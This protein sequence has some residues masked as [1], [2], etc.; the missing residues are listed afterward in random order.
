MGEMGKGTRKRRQEYLSYRAKGLAM[1][2][3]KISVTHRKMAV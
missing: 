1:D 3:E 2:R